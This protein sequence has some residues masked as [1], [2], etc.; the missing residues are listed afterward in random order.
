MR[1]A[2]DRLIVALDVPSAEE[3][4]TLI[5]RWLGVSSS[6]VSVAHGGKS[7]SRSLA[8]RRHCRA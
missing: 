8:M 6:T 3:A 4:R 2:R 1:S 7:R 5:A